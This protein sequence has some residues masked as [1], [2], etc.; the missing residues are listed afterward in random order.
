MPEGPSIVILRESLSSFRGKKVLG[1]SGNAKIDLSKIENKKVIDFKSW[2]K[3]FLI[4]FNGFYLRIHLMMFGTYRINE[5][6]DA[7]PRLSLLFRNGEVNFY[8]CSVRLVENDVEDDYDWQSD[9]MA[10]EW[11]PA[12]ALKKLKAL[13]KVNVCDALLNQEIFSGVGNIIKNEVLFR[14]KVHP[15]SSVE[16]LPP[17]KVKE[18]VK[19]ASNYS[20]DFYEWKKKFELKKH[21]LIYKKKECPR[22]KIPARR[23]YMG[24]GKRL[25]SW[26]DNCQ[27]LYK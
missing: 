11:K 14:I 5:R 23:G 9:V 22:C 7:K 8:T 25:T 6:K 21:W 17:R 1:A 24:K 15:A 2:G 3:H 12:K 20:F 18:L 4:C 19:E 13:G 27:V 10:E 16:A 26:C